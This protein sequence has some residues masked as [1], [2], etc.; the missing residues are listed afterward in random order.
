VCVLCYFGADLKSTKTITGTTIM[1][2]TA[3]AIVL[4][5]ASLLVFNIA[6]QPYLH[7]R[8]ALKIVNTVLGHWENDNLTL[9]MSYW[10]KEIDSP[11]VYGLIDYEIGKGEYNKKDGVYSADIAATL[12]FNLDNLLPTGEEWTFHLKKTHAGWK[13]TGFRLS[14]NNLP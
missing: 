6:L 11:P 3:I 13:I 5:I 14:G 12:N 7:R 10:D 1:N 2:K 4:L 9:A 8:D